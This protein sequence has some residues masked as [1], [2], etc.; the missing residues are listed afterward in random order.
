MKRPSR[1]QLSPAYRPQLNQPCEERGP[2]GNAGVV[3]LGS[4]VA[5]GLD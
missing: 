5:F 1:I 4:G 3:T 2:N